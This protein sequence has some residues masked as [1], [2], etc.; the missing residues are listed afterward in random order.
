M[1]WTALSHVA[2]PPAIERFV[3]VGV[4]DRAKSITALR[5]TDA[6]VETYSDLASLSES[7]TAVEQESQVV[8]LVCPAEESA[9]GI[10]GADGTLGAEK[11][12]GGE[13]TDF[14]REMTGDEGTAASRVESV[15]RVVRDILKSLQ[16]WLEQER[17]AGSRCVI[18]TTGAVMTGADD[19][20][21]GMA[22][23]AI[24]GLV[25]SAQ[26][27]NPGRL[28]LVDLDRREEAWQELPA[29]LAAALESE[30]SQIAIRDGAVLVPRLAKAATQSSILSGGEEVFEREGTTLITGGTG[31][32]GTLVAKHLVSEHGVRSLVLA[33][34]SGLDAPGALQLR[35]ELVDLGAHVQ[36]TAC[37]VAD[38]KQV[39]KL[40][41]SVPA[42]YPLRSVVHAAGVIEDG[43]IGSLTPDAVD[44]VLASKVDAALHL[45]ELTSHMDL[46]T[47]VL[48][49]SLAGTF[50]G[51]GQGNYAA[52][53]ASLDALA[54]RRHACGLPAVSIAWGLWS[55]DAGMGATLAEGDIARIG[56][57][58]MQALSTEQGLKLF[59][60][61]CMTQRAFVG[62]AHFDSSALRSQARTGALPALLRGLVRMPTGGA[63]HGGDRAF[64]RRLAQASP[65]G[66]QAIVLSLVRG[67]VAN[68]LG[69]RS[70]EKIPLERVFQELGFDSLAAVEL[71]NA[72]ESAIGLRLPSTVVFDYPSISQ[73]S[74]YLSTRLLDGQSK[75]VAKVIASTRSDEPIAIVGMAC[76]YPGG[77]DSPEALWKMVLEE[78]DAISAFPNDRGWDLDALYDPDPDRHGTTYVREGGF[79]EDAADFDAE[80]FGISPREALAMDPQQRLLLESC[81]ESLEYAGVDPL[82]LKGTQAGVFTGV[83]HHDYALRDLGVVPG[84]L[85]AYLATGTA[86]SV[87]SGRV[88]YTLGVEGPAVTVD[89][90][91]SSSLVALHMA[92]GS[93]R[94]GECSLAL[95]GGVTVLATPALFIGFSRQRGLA[96]DARCKS[97]ANAANGTSWS[98]GV[99]MLALER[100]SDA[101]RLGHRVL[102]VVRGSAVNQDGASN[103]LTAPNGPSQE[104]V[105]RQALA[106]AGLTADEIDAVEGHGTGTPL[107]DP[108][109]INAVGATYGTDR[110]SAQ[111]V[112]L[113][114]IK[115]NIGHAQ[116][117]A[118]VAG[119]IKMVMAM[120]HGILPAT[121]HIDE[122]S[123]QV[124]WE[125]SSVSLLTESMPWS[126][127]S[128]LRRAAVSSFGVSGTNAHAILEEAPFEQSVASGPASSQAAG[129]GAIAEEHA[130]ESA[131]E[132]DHGPAVASVDTVEKQRKGVLGPDVLPWVFSSRSRQA[133]RDQAERLRSFAA[134]DDAPRAIDVGLSL[135]ARPVFEHRGIAVGSDRDELLAGLDALCE[136]GPAA[137]SLSGLAA[138]SVGAKVAF[139]FPGQGSQWAGMA[140][141]LLSCSEVFA[142]RLFECSEVLAAFVDWRL[143]AVLRAEP[144]APS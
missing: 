141:E 90:A 13:D 51:P 114:S 65:Q 23:S 44:R 30:E 56:R 42:E 39:E 84:D 125:Q 74:A 121:L 19:A 95:A 70:P 3:V 138:S 97:Y 43:V 11:V 46:S 82:A 118:G 139:A 79:I 6:H 117:A 108:I 45:H 35:D 26:A 66:Q 54:M 80:F 128:G 110:L 49:S 106:N 107:G 8:L 122:P 41:A 33:S 62:A 76:R 105:I 75:T 57:G 101:R 104:R 103:G 77:V 17:P 91:C 133:L 143:E 18:V 115:S 22:S 131:R 126:V 83:M 32:M 92:C 64:A 136:K 120:R 111:P 37:D 47:F 16:E 78:V 53:N 119:V 21:A 61:A 4:A 40:I 85:E 10:I 142:N 59:D 60:A 9:E 123:K 38:R 86:G 68:V 137:A 55:A 31:A 87:V 144:G 27:E 99:G 63:S 14:D 67:E 50:G 29:A 48:F 100:V 5:A 81:W 88:A 28:M 129:G 1:N 12:V 135:L 72:L 58:G 130:V 102:A 24:W 7:S 98:E 20:V 94:D 73:L 36:V 34:R 109:E 112:R 25:R 132:E 2:S 116:A 89:T 124:D 96:L 113:G 71:R 15:H 140:V 69:H 127:T 52:A 93:L 134:D